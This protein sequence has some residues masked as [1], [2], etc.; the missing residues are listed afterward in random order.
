MNKILILLGLVALLGG[1]SKHCGEDGAKI[2][3]VTKPIVEALAAYTKE[4]GEPKS[5]MDVDGIPYQLTSC[6]QNLKL[7]ECKILKNGYYFKHDDDYFVIRIDSWG[8]QHN[9][10]TFFELRVKHSYTRCSYMIYEDGKLK[11][12]YLSPR[13]GVLPS[14][15]EGWKQ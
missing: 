7:H 11:D 12:N 4:H 9:Q 15:G 10:S 5:I 13:C 6:A 2:Q 8:G 1:C 3:K 14:C